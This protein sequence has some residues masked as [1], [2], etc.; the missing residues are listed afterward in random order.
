[1]E[2]R[3]LP[4]LDGGRDLCITGS[5]LLTASDDW[6]GRDIRFFEG[7]DAWC[8]HAAA[9]VRLPATLMG[10]ERVTLVESL[11]RGPTHTYISHY[12][13]DFTGR[14]FLFTPDGLMPEIQAKSAA[15][16]MDKVLRQVG[17]RPVKYDYLGI[18]QQMAGHIKELASDDKMI[19]SDEVGK[20]WTENGLPR[21]ASAPQDLVPQPPDLVPWWSTSTDSV[22]ELTGPFLREEG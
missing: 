13:S 5:C 4:Y 2:I 11:E 8:S 3:N 17:P 12:F 22:V 14:L 7:N 20:S 10:R 16:L 1:M 18:I 9:I 21:L 6:I 19:C 15:W